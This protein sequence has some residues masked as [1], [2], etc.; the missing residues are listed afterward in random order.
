MRWI[1]FV[2]VLIYCLA[3]PVYA[4]II[5]RP[6]AKTQ[7]MTYKDLPCSDNQKAY[8]YEII[9]T[10]GE[11]SKLSLLFK[12]GHLKELGAHINEVHPFKFLAVIFSHPHLKN[13]MMVIWSDYFKRNGF[14]DGL[15]PSLSREAE[16]G[17]LLPYLADFSAEL[18]VHPEAVQ[19]YINAQDWEGLV[20]FLIQS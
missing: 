9:S 10:M 8:I 12:Q 7:E 4:S 19:A 3:A 5:K 11:N 16:K 13:C 17:K 14:L 18:N 6:P 2:W 20:V 15:A 1:G